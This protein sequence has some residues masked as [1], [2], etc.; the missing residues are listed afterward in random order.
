MDDEVNGSVPKSHPGQLPKVSRISK[1][2]PVY[3]LSM[4]EIVQIPTEQCLFNPET[5]CGPMSLSLSE[6]QLALR[7]SIF[8]SAASCG[9]LNQTCRLRDLRKSAQ[10]CRCCAIF[11][12]L[13][14]MYL[15][16]MIPDSDSPG[17]IYRDLYRFSC[18]VEGNGTLI[19]IHGKGIRLHRFITYAK[20]S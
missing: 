13:V 7:P 17:F 10:N 20:G 19:A 4:N 15:S 2:P 8:S 1:F 16:Y 14:E 18:K 11:Y 5:D 3:S 9:L 12:G 6:N